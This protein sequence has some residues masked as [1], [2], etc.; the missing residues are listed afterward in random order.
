MK[1]P[2]FIK[3][4]EILIVGW[5]SYQVSNSLVAHCA[6]S[7]LPPYFKTLLLSDL[8]LTNTMDPNDF[9]GCVTLFR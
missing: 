5:L 2:S 9:S 1:L 8:H 7:H 6:F 4:D 3:I